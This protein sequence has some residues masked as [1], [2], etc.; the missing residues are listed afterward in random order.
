MD[1][2]RALR[3][4]LGAPP[5]VQNSQLSR[6]NPQPRVGSRR[7]PADGSIEIYD[8]VWGKLFP[9]DYTLR[10]HEMCCVLCC[11]CFAGGCCTERKRTIWR[12]VVK[13]GAL[14]LSLLQIGVF[15]VCLAK[16][17]IDDSNVLIGPPAATLIQLGA[18]DLGRMRG[19]GCP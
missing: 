17:G 8:P 13:R 4:E 6:A 10:P 3:R 16:G 9:D 14:V 15:G 1:D 7:P 18:K 19:H 5:R 2:L 11:P 12:R